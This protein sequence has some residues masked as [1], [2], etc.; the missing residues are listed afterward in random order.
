MKN[1]D[2]ISSFIKRLR[3]NIYCKEDKKYFDFLINL[4]KKKISVTEVIFQFGLYIGQTNLSRYLNF[5]ELYKKTLTLRGDCCDIGTWKGSS[6][7]FIAKLIRIFEPHSK[8]KIYG[9]DWFKGQSP[10]KNDNKKFKGMYKS[11]FKDLKYNI[12]KLNLKDIA[13]IKKIN[14]AKKLEGFLKNKPWLI[15]KYAFLDCGSSDVLHSAMKNIWPRIISGGILVLDHY[16][17][18]ST[19]QEKNI[20]NEYIGRHKVH[21]ISF[22]S[23]PAAYIIKK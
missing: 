1:F 21:Q 13:I 12:S 2:T 11:N 14:I 3:Q 17:F 22:S 19:P 20:I 4:E 15:F 23:H 8:T 7:L 16:G 6:F 10:K 18:E 9:F 5:Y